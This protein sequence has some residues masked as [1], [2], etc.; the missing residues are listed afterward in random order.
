[1]L[2]LTAIAGLDPFPGSD[3]VPVILTED[4]LAAKQDAAV[5]VDAVAWAARITR[6]STAALFQYRARYAA[7]FVNY[8]TLRRLDTWLFILKKSLIP[9]ITSRSYA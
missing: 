7:H 6:G 8:P 2:R 1:M 4:G 5:M 9:R 3:R